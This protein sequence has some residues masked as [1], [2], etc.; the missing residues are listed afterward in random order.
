MRAGTAIH[1]LG[2]RAK[3]KRA[4]TRAYD[5]SRTRVGVRARTSPGVC[6]VVW[7]SRACQ[8]PGTSPV[9]HAPVRA[10]EV[11]QEVACQFGLLAFF[12]G[13]MSPVGSPV[14][15]VHTRK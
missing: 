6:V 9:A 14:G 10:V 11:V 5:F 15:H 13:P 3:Y 2:I 1:L 7:Q 4:N 8:P 12:Y